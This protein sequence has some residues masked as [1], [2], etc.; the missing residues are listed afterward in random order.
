VQFSECLTSDE[1]LERFHE[2]LG[3]G[4]LLLRLVVVGCVGSRHWSR[5]FR[6][7]FLG[8]NVLMESAA[9]YVLATAAAAAAAERL[10][11]RVNGP[12]FLDHRLQCTTRIDRQAVIVS[13]T[14]FLQCGAPVTHPIW[15]VV[16]ISHLTSLR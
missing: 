14:F 5:F 2:V 11:R 9:S 10:T 16:R 15:Q 3:G 7:W 6:N 12:H 8:W 4:L 13:S 1:V